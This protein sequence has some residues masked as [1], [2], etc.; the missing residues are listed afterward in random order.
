MLSHELLSHVQLFVTPLT[1][2]HQAPLSIRIL[3]ARILKCVPCPP[4]GGLPNPGIEPRLPTLQA[5]SLLSEP[6]GKPKNTRVGSLSLLQCVFP[7]Q[8]SNQCLLPCRQILYQL[9]YQGSLIYVHTHTH[10]HTHTPRVKYYSAIKGWNSAI[11][12]N[13]NGCRDHCALFFF[14][15]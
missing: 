3:Q 11:F 7:T 12:N 9:S 6:L 13:L 1:V 10:T 5:D 15:V 2:A 8:E 4:P 14:L